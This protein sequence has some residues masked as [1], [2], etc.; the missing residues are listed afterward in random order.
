MVRAAN[1]KLETGNTELHTTI[2]ING[3][4]VRVLV[5]TGSQRSLI[6]DAAADRLG[7]GGEQRFHAGALR[8]F[9]GRQ[10]SGIG[11]LTIG[12]MHGTNL[13]FVTATNLGAD[14]VVLGIDYLTPFDVDLDLWGKHLGLYRAISGCRTPSAALTSGLYGVDLVNTYDE[15]HI[16]SPAVRITTGGQQFIAMIDTGA[17]HSTMLRAAAARAGL[18]PVAANADLS[19]SGFGLNRVRAA[20]RTLP[21]LQIGDLTIQNMP[22]VLADSG[23]L[24]DY[25]MILGYDFISRVHVWISH[26]SNTLIMQFPPEATPVGAVDIENN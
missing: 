8:G 21:S 14:E 20:V 4:E 6:T 15:Q 17:F 25:D 26:S 24:G 18:A 3:Q 9:G 22:I 19:I 2:G 23:P 7:L 11:K 1:L 12:T 13:S 10:T 16:I 5:D